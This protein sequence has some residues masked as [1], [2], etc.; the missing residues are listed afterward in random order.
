MARG[1]LLMI[2][3]PAP[4]TPP[5]E[6]PP[7]NPLAKAVKETVFQ[8]QASQALESVKANTSLSEHFGTL[9]DLRKSGMVDHLIVH[10]V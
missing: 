2:V 3:P 6:L 1:K 10:F 7:L 9:S 4:S 8:A 5:T